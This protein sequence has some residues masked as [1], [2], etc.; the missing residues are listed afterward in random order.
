MQ[1]ATVP[2]HRNP[3]PDTPSARSGPK[4]HCILSSEEVQGFPSRS[5][6]LGGGSLIVGRFADIHGVEHRT[7]IS[8]YSQGGSNY[9]EGVEVYKV[10]AG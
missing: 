8:C 2:G 4:T 3:G 6:H 9:L 10:L 7:G 1:L 5:N